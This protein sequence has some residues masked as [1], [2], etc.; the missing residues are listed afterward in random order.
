MSRLVSWKKR[1]DTWVL[2]SSLGVIEMDSSAVRPPEQMSALTRTPNRASD[3]AYRYLRSLIFTRQL[4]PGDRLPPERALST[5][6][7]IGPL[8]LRV[9]LRALE[10]E[11]F[12]TIKLGAKG[13]PRINDADT[14]NACWQTWMRAHR[15]EVMELLEFLTFVQEKIAT[16]AALRRT[17]EDL[18]VL[19]VAANCPSDGP[20]SL[21]A[22]HLDFLD[23]LARAAHNRSLLQ[24]LKAGDQELFI[25][26]MDPDNDPF[27]QQ[28]VDFRRRMLAAV[29]DGDSARAV[30][31]VKDQMSFLEDVFES[32]LPESE[33]RGL[34]E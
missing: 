9:A 11:G 16:S 6:L 15:D 27:A 3:E 25:P 34:P 19:E 21:L 4:A 30:E 20:V 18:E 17:A 24:A 2:P 33:R 12:L 32:W 10:A 14:L 1:A 31:V 26:V 8:T 5:Q 29:Q 13:G 28:N 22:Q 7:G 23:A